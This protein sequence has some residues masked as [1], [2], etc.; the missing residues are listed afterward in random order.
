MGCGISKQDD[1]KS[2]ENELWSEKCKLQKIKGELTL[3]KRVCDQLG[4]N[5]EDTVDDNI[6][7]IARLHAKGKSRAGPCCAN[8]DMNYI[9]DDVWDVKKELNWPTLPMHIAHDIVKEY[10]THYDLESSLENILDKKAYLPNEFAKFN[11]FFNGEFIPKYNRQNS[12]SPKLMNNSISFDQFI[13]CMKRI[14]QTNKENDQ[15]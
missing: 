5:P 2:L 8:D 13:N 3:Y 10:I 7:R 12:G 1:M 9:N 14:L 11:N 4:I 15:K 6:E